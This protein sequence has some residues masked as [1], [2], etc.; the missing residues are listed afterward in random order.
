VACCD[1][2]ERGGDGGL[3]DPALAGDPEEVEVE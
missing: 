2:G 3:A 1:V